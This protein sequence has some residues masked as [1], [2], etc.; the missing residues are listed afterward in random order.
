[1]DKNI[2]I[3]ASFFKQSFTYIKAKTIHIKNL[4]S[5]LDYENNFYQKAILH[6]GQMVYG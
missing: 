4:Y 1:M 3:K 2:Q 5:T 6:R